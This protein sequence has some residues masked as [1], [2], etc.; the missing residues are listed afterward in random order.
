MHVILELTSRTV[1]LV[2]AALGRYTA[3]V[4]QGSTDDGVPVLAV[5]P[6]LVPMIPADDPAQVKF[7]NERESAGGIPRPEVAAFAREIVL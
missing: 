5:I 7:E 3:Q 4:W 1:D 2:D 6:V